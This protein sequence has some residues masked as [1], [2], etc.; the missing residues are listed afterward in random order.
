MQQTINGGGDEKV[1]IQERFHLESRCD[2]QKTYPHLMDVNVA[3]NAISTLVVVNA[4]TS[5]YYSTISLFGNV[6]QKIEPEVAC[7]FG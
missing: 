2:E 6:T 4:K 3:L 7:E 5:E 1:Y